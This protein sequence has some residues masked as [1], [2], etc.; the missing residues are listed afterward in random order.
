MGLL[1]RRRESNFAWILVVIISGSESGTSL[2]FDVILHGQEFV[3]LEPEHQHSASPCDS[4]A[5]VSIPCETLG[6]GLAAAS[7]SG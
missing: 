2:L 1:F 3:V 5:V 7:N 6:L 4:L